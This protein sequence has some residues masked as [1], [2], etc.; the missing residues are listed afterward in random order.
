MRKHWTVPAVLLFL[1]IL[2][3]PWVWARQETLADEAAQPSLPTAVNASLLIAAAPT[4]IPTTVSPTIAPTS[5]PTPTSSPTTPP[6]P[7]PSPTA[8]P[9]AAPMPTASI[10]PT[11]EPADPPLLRPAIAP[12]T[13]V[14]A[15]PAVVRASQ[16]VRLIIPAIGLNLKPVSVGLDRWRTPIVPKH[17]AG[18]YNNS[19][20]PGQ[21]SNVVFWGHVLR[22]L[23]SPNVPAPF[24]RVRELRPGAEIRVVTADGAVH[25]YRVSRQV[26]VRPN[27]VEYILPTPSERLTLVSCIGD[28]VIQD[29]T[30]TKKFRLITIAEPVD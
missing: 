12:P 9:I 15:P 20:M 11:P 19:A 1:V 10:I 25:R 28:K 14:P 16:P 3:R 18:W 27:Q 4:L 5:P 7:P 30:L 8:L 23:D 2:A 13:P 6:T 29:G 21:P 22:W 26:Q 17:E 24:A